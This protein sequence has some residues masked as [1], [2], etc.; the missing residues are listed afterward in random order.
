MSEYHPKYHPQVYYDAQSLLKSLEISHE[1]KKARRTLRRRIGEIIRTH[2]GDEFDVE[3]VCMREYAEDVDIAPIELMIVDKSNPSG[4]APGTNFRSLPDVYYPSRVAALLQ[5]HGFDGII[6]STDVQRRD[7]IPRNWKRGDPP[8]RIED[9][10]FPWPQYMRPS[11]PEII[12][13]AVLVATTPQPFRLSLPCPT[14]RHTLDLLHSY[15]RRNPFLRQMICLIYIWMRSWGINEISPVTLSL[16]VIRFFQEEEVSRLTDSGRS[17]SISA[18]H[19]QASVHYTTTAWMPFDAREGLNR[20]ILL[21]ISYALFPHSQPTRDFSVVLSRFLRWIVSQR[22]HHKHDDEKNWPVLRVNCADHSSSRFSEEIRTFDVTRLPWSRHQL[23]VPDPFVPTH[24]HAFN[25]HRSTLHYLSVLADA[26]VSLLRTTHP[27]HTIFGPYYQPESVVEQ[28]IRSLL[29]PPIRPRTS[30][31]SIGIRMERQQYFTNPKL[32]DELIKLSNMT[33]SDQHVRQKRQRTIANV[34]RSIRSHFGQEFRIG[35]FGSTQYGVDGRNSDLDLVVIDPDRMTG[36]SP[37]V[38]LDELPRIYK[39]SEVSIALQ[40]SGFRILE[41][42]PRAT[43]PIVKF[44]DPRTNIE[45][46]LNI[47]DQLGT[48]NT[49][50][51]RHYC[52]ILPILR[53]LLLAIK[54]WARPLGYNNPAGAA[55]KPISF[56]SY[57]LTI[58][59]IGL[60]QTRGLLPNLQEGT[61]LSEGRTIWLRTNTQERIRCNARWKNIQDWTP[62]RVV[63]V[64]QALEDWFQY[65]GHEH[66]YCND[67]ISV[68]WGGVVPRRLPC[69]RQ[70][71]ERLRDGP[72]SGFR[73]SS[74]ATSGNS[75][76]EKS[77]TK[78]QQI[79]EDTLSEADANVLEG[80]NSGDKQAPETVA[81]GNS[82]DGP[83]LTDENGEKAEGEEESDTWSETEQN[84]AS[85]EEFDVAPEAG[86]EAQ[87]FRWQSDMLCVADPFI[88]TKNLAGPIKPNVIIRFREDCQRV[89]MRLFN[90]GNLNS[91]LWFDP[92]TRPPSP[93][94]Q[95]RARPRQQQAQGQEG[96]RRGGGGGNRVRR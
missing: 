46:D 13:P 83:P 25:V 89:V 37:D 15:G 52:D 73:S 3:D 29:P 32:R 67:L 69:N 85:D 39:I 62:P 34:E 96:G 63:E 23:I 10:A 79:K 88:E 35:A 64:E 2:A 84:L 50:L 94:S 22:F 58:M 76:A 60:L 19:A 42:V 9:T 43:V 75:A 38:D 7:G 1:R 91:L 8:P 21:N 90:G 86:E 81:R 82:P 74:N 92:R 49:S 61:E 48:I 65:W 16:L 87:P 11:K 95:P 14:I 45:C 36:F 41:T 12:Y 71:S 18:E 26:C 4:L 27:L 6:Q 59:T 30:G 20:S 93:T 77:P 51:I 68:R 28:R 70:E 31:A 72:F 40:Y 33:S 57:T 55:G 5:D 56:S 54:R 47:N 53:P 24:N 66:D 80:Q 78:G 17:T 44:K